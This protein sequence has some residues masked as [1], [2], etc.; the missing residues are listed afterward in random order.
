MVGSAT[1]MTPGFSV[2]ITDSRTG[3]GYIVYP[4]GNVYDYVKGSFV[5]V[6]GIN[7]LIAYIKKTNTGG[8]IIFGNDT[9]SNFTDLGNFTLPDFNFSSQNNTSI[10]NDTGIQVIVVP[11]TFQTVEI[12]GELFNIYSNGSVFSLNGTLVSTGGKEGLI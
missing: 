10:I 5:T 2:I 11:P 12:N 6:G 7:G 1:I 9:S 8:Q 3:T 4:D